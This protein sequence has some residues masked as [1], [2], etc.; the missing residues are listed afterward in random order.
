[1]AWGYLLAAGL[2]EIGWAIGLKYSAGFTRLVPSILTIASIAASLGL[3]GLALSTLPVGQA[4][5][6]WTGVG[7][8]GTAALGVLLF[9]ESLT[10]M[11]VLSIALIL[12]GVIGLKAA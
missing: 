1:M 4:Y 9:G 8:T 6:I 12:A 2:L 5:A 11:K 3:L 10:L 7:I